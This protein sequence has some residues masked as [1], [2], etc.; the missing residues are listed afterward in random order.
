MAVPGVTVATVPCAGPDGT[1]ASCYLSIGGALRGLLSA[2]HWLPP[3]SLT[4]SPHLTGFWGTAAWPPEFCVQLWYWR[5]RD[6]KCDT[7]A[8]CSVHGSVPDG[9]HRVFGTHKRT[10]VVY[11][12]NVKVDTCPHCLP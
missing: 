10:C 4:V 2:S 5:Q 11:I 12:R 7:P 8:L 9:L 3:S 1:A 6:R